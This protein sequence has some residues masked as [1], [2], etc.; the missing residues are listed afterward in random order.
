MSDTVTEL[1]RAIA[2]QHGLS[3]VAASLLAGESVEELDASAAALARL[4]GEGREEP[5]SVAEAAL[6]DLFDPR[7]RA[8]RKQALTE[9]FAGQPPQPREQSRDSQGRFTR[10]GSFDGGARQPTPARES[11]ERE[12]DALIGQLAGLS[13]TFR[14][15]S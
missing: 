3:P 4:V 11:P 1:R 14:T 7:A 9:L 2:A 12:H 13:R 6:A 15:G 5:E 10:S 8:R